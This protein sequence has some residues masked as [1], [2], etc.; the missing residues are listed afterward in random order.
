M[1]GDRRL[2]IEVVL[3]CDGEDREGCT[4]HAFSPDR[5][6]PSGESLR[7]IQAGLTAISGRVVHYAHLRDF[8]DN[9]HRHREAI[10]F[11]YWFGVLSRSRHALVPAIC[12]AYGI[13]YVGADAYTKAICND[14]YL[15]KSLCEL[16]GLNAAPGFLLTCDEDLSLLSRCNYPRVVKPNFQGSS[17]GIDDSS[18]VTQATEARSAV[19]RTVQCFGWPV[20]CEEFISGREISICMMGNHRAPT[21]LRALSWEMNGDPAFLDHRLFSYTL[22][23]AASIQFRPIILGDLTEVQHRACERLFGLLDKVEIMRIDGRLAMNGLVVLE[24]SPDLDL[25][26][27]GEAAVAFGDRFESYA[28]FLKQLLLNAFERCGRQPPMYDEG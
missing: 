6:R 24:L 8:V 27:D 16:V 2:N 22:K 15:S 11:P 12:E 19:E 5:D 1:V 23:T 10:V 13:V 17:L 28:Q 18:L 14:K 25:R 3:V 7:L 20:L 4:A 21:A 9:L 26:P